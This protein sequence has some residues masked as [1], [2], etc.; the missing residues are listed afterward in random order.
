MRLNQ[1]KCF[2]TRLVVLASCVVIGLLTG[3]AAHQIVK[4]YPVKGSYYVSRTTFND[5][6]E[7]Y[8]DSR[9]TLSEEDRLKIEPIFHEGK[10]ALDLWGGAI[11]AD[12]GTIVDKQDAYYKIKDELFRLLFQYG[13]LTLSPVEGGDG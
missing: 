10:T 6:L 1:S 7:S 5:A 11:K 2:L 4:Q 3:C 12:D 8:L 9:Y 13:I